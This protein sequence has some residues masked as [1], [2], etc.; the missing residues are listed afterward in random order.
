MS[1]RNLSLS[2]SLSLGAAL[3]L[4]A[5]STNQA[6][7]VA[8]KSKGDMTLGNA[9]NGAFDTE[10]AAACGSLREGR[11]AAGAAIGRAPYLQ[12]VTDK[13]ASVVWTTSSATPETVVAWKATA[14]AEPRQIAARV[15]DTASPAQGA[16]VQADLTDLEPSTIYCYEIRA[17]ET[18]V[19]ALSGFRTAPSAGADVK[20]RFVALGD[21]GT[22]SADQFAVFEQMQ[23]VPHDFVLMTGDI[24]YDTG[25]LGSFE[26]NVFDVYEGYLDKVPVFPAVGNHDFTTDKAGPYRQV[27]VLPRNGAR[28]SEYTYSFDWGPV[29]VAV[30]DTEQISDAQAQWLDADLTATKQPWKIVMGHKPPYSSGDH[31]NNVPVQQTFGPVMERHGVQLTLWG[32][33]H[34][35]ERTNPINGVTYIVTGGG[36]RGTRPVGKSSFTAFS[37]E[38]EHIVYVEIEGNTLKAWAVDATGQ[39]FD[40]VKITR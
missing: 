15:D 23:N 11:T 35:Y 12:M 5:C 1:T 14:K 24:A 4:A 37:Q 38:V 13:S 3:A 33:D 34:N 30:I 32:H 20:V 39:T 2:L 31:G 10:L 8:A 6:G 25:T 27:F 16:Q 28:A 26:R 22:A 40:T 18:A 36:G 19:H 29:H 9:P 21:L 17:G 7:N